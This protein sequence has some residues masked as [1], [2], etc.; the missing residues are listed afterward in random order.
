MLNSLKRCIKDPVEY[1]WWSLFRKIVITTFIIYYM[2][3]RVFYALLSL[4][5]RIFPHSDKDQENSEYGHFSHSVSQVVPVFANTATVHFCKFLSLSVSRMYIH[6]IETKYW[7]AL[8]AKF[9]KN[10]VQK[11]AY[12]VTNLKGVFRIQSS[13]YAEVFL[14]K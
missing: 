9:V 12:S 11:W 14:W 3:K 6:F 1:L 2:F 5:L 10:F 4:L 13:I 7:R 8:K